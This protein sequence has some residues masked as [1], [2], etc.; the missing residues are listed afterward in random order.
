M[1]QT[2]RNVPLSNVPK[3]EIRQPV[4][5][6]FSL[7]NLEISTF[8]PRFALPN[9]L[10][11]NFALTNRA[12][13]T[14]AHEQHQ[15]YYGQH[16]CFFKNTQCARRGCRISQHEQLN[17]TILWQRNLSHVMATRLLRISLICSAKLLPSIPSLRLQPWRNTL[18][19]GLLRVA[20]ISLVKLCSFR[21]CSQKAVLQVL[22][23]VRFRLVL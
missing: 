6:L 20:R 9:K 13:R 16:Q 11:C 15:C 21:K 8:F 23:T 4:R 18:T 12:F 2:L 14:T 10:N 22:F 7:K 19:N 1:R 17:L 3:N 5:P